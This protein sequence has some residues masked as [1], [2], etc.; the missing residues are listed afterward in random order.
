MVVLP[1]P[2]G[3]SR[4]KNWPDCNFQVEIVDGEKI[5]VALGS[6]RG[7]DRPTVMRKA[8][9]RWPR[10]AQA[11]VRPV[12]PKE[13]LGSGAPFDATILARSTASVTT[14][15]NRGDLSQTGSAFVCVA[16]Q[17]E[18][19]GTGNRRSPSPSPDTSGTAPASRR[20]R[21]RR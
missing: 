17:Q 11:R 5:A 10:R 21:D 7:A 18:T 20:R 14:P 16:G 9:V 4:P 3:P 6:A 12:V 19:P 8:D 2:F 15:W 13:Q 1:E